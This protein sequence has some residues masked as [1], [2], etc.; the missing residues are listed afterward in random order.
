VEIA[1]GLRELALGVTAADVRA[2]PSD[3][4]PNVWGVLMDIGFPED[5]VTLVAFADGTTSLYFS[6]GGGVIGA[7]EHASVREATNAFLN[8]VEAHLERFPIARDTAGPMAGRVRFHVRTFGDP[9]SAEADEQALGNGQHP[10]SPVFYAAHNVITAARE[11][12]ERF[13][14]SP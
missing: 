13:Q 5:V 3:D 6:T 9:R 11:A 1:R 10:L 14:Q 2:E 4:R 7:G 12:T 8:T